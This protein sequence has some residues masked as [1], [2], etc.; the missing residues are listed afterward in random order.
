MLAVL[1]DGLIKPHTPGSLREPA[2]TYMFPQSWRTIPL[3]FGLLMCKRIHHYFINLSNTSS[4]MGR[5]FRLPKHL[6]RHE[7]RLQIPSSRRHH[8]HLQFHPRHRHGRPRPPHVRRLSPRRN[9]IKHPSHKRLPRSTKLYHRN[10]HSHHP[11]H[12]NPP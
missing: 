6:Q 10:L 7:T 5:P 3:A 4:S 9:N 8:L 2:Q 12:Q 1:A 11:P